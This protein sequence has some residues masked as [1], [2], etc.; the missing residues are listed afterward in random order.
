VRR[1]VRYDA[2]TRRQ[3]QRR[4]QKK[5]TNKRS[6]PRRMSVRG[7]AGAST[8]DQRRDHHRRLPGLVYN[9]A[10]A[11]NL[12]WPP[13]TLSKLEDLCMRRNMLTPCTQ[14]AWPLLKAW[15]SPTTI[16]GSIWRGPAPTHPEQGQKPSLSQPDLQPDQT[17]SLPLLSL[18]MLPVPLA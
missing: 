11:L 7:K 4:D 5:I 6:G 2:L 1:T 17:W 14:H 12:T 8:L 16:V 18:T 15:A 10:L 13:Q 9:L 3:T